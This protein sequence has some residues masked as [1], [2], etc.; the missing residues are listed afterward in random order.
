MRDANGAR[1]ALA[2]F[3]RADRRALRRARAYTSEAVFVSRLEIM[4]RDGGECYLCGRELSIHDANLEHVIPL[5]RGG[6]HTP[7]NIKIAHG[8]CNKKK[9]ER[10]LS[11]I[12]FSEW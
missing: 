8:L 10:L 2:Y 9:G 5:T 4:G 6:S 12:D 3:R 1:A 7:D 11:E